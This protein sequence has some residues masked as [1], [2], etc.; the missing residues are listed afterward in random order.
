MP[1]DDNKDLNN[2]SCYGFYLYGNYPD[3]VDT[4]WYYFDSSNNGEIPDDELNYQ[5]S[6]I[7]NIEATSTMKWKILVR[8]LGSDINDEPHE[9]TNVVVQVIMPN[10]RIGSGTDIDVQ[11]VK[12]NNSFSDYDDDVRNKSDDTHDFTIINYDINSD[13]NNEYNWDTF[14]DSSQAEDMI[15]D[16]YN[17][18]DDV[19]RKPINNVIDHGEQRLTLY[20]IDYVVSDSSTINERSD[21]YE[22]GYVDITFANEVECLEWYMQKYRADNDTKLDW[23]L[24]WY[25]IDNTKF[26]WNLKKC[27][28]DN[29]YDN[30]TDANK[31]DQVYSMPDLLDYLDNICS[32]PDPLKCAHS[33]QEMLSLIDPTGCCVRKRKDGECPDPEVKLYHRGAHRR[34]YLGNPVGETDYVWG[35]NVSMINNPTVCEAKLHKRHNILPFHYVR[36]MISRGYINL[37]HLASEWNFTNILTQHWSYQSS[38]YELIQPVFHHSGNT[39]A[40]F[41]DDTLELDVSIAAEGAIFCILGCEKRQS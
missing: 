21:N 28:V 7:N 8:R 9:E 1:I 19:N 29:I 27:R 11:V 31:V 4:Y 13:D 34:R 2:N 38:Y 37:Q 20:I 22:D 10:D 33:P 5:T 41:L 6:N 14:H 16:T 3:N 25:R 39:V 17:G 24:K 26:E 40:L 15:D 12:N 35:D 36:S 32:N 23:I 30:N 18:D